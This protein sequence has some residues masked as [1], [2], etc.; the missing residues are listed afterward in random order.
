MF[1]LIFSSSKEHYKF[2]MFSFS[3]LVNS[4]SLE[5][6][7]RC[8]E[9]CKL[10]FCSRS[11]N[12]KVV[13]AHDKLKS[14][15][16]ELES[17]PLLNEEPADCG[18]QGDNDG[19]GDDASEEKQITMMTWKPFGAFFDE[20]LKVI[21]PCSNPTYP[22]NPLYQ[23]EFM[24]K[25]QQNWLPMSPFWSSILRGNLM[26]VMFCIIYYYC[27]IHFFINVGDPTRYKNWSQAIRL[28]KSY[29]QKVKSNIHRHFALLP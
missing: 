12:T 6:L 8:V 17:L 5:S 13:C 3:L 27:I 22:T 15:F 23:P 29:Q 10:V 18:V 4:S 24:A 16:K 28:S 26:I 9:T 1:S 21:V 14:W 7:L 19:K 2:A 11:I 25:L 20:K